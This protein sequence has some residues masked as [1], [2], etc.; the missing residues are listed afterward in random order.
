[1]KATRNIPAEMPDNADYFNNDFF[2]RFTLRE[3]SGPLRLTDS[4]SRNYLF[5]TF[6]GDVT[7][8][9]GIFPCSYEKAARLVSE[10]LHPDVKPVKMTKGRSLIA[11]SCY[12]YKNVM[13]VAPYNEVAMAIPVMV[14]AK[15]SPPLLPMIM[16]SFSR[17]GYYIAG[18]PV[19]SYEN[20][21]RGNRIWGLPKVTQDIDIRK[22]GNDC[23]TTVYE[24]SGEAYLTLKVPMDGKPQRFDVTSNL[25]TRLN[26]RLL[27][28]E[29]NFMAD[30]RVIKYMDQLFKKGVKPDRNYI[31][32]GNTPSA[33]FLRDLDIEEHPFQFRYTGQMSSCF[34][35]P[36]TETPAWLDALNR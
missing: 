31:Q 16:S 11:F 3:A 1:M 6:Y 10:N 25:Y 5:P 12:E 22:E 7:C 23:V 4:I 27:Q 29:T 24:E 26:G 36:K 9:I 17:F 14:N 20:Q 18:M 15:F 35:L 28:N 30:F 34:D 8:A 13:G 2:R 21:L 32:I 19:T 33:K